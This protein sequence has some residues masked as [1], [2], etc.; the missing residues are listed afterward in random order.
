MVLFPLLAIALMGQDAFR[1]APPIS[2]NPK[3]AI[4]FWATSYF[5]YHAV[6]IAN[7]IPLLDMAGKPLGPSLSKKDWCNAALEGTV[8][9]GSVTYNFAG[10]GQTGFIDCIAYFVPKVGFT[11]FEISKEPMGHGAPGFVLVPYRTVAADPE[12]LLAGAVLFM[13]EAVGQILPDGQ[14]H[15][16][17]FMVADTGSAIKGNHLDIFQ[18]DQIVNFPFI[19]GSSDRLFQAYPIKDSAIESQLLRLHKRAHGN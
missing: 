13:P 12:V 10:V 15:D 6:N 11:R 9:I 7:G 1:L 5:V 18:G 8:R 17:Y 3:D 16:G 2:L 19:R 4:S 14:K